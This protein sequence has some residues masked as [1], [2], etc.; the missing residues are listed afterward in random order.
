[1]ALGTPPYS[2]RRTRP[3]R[4]RSALRRWVT[5][6][7]GRRLLAAWVGAHRAGSLQI[8]PISPLSHPLRRTSPTMQPRNLAA[9]AGRWSATHRKT[10]IIGWLAFVVLA[11]LDRRQ[12]RPEDA[13]DARRWATATPSAPS[14]SST[15]RTSPQTVGERVLVQGKGSVKA[16]GPEVTAAVKDV[17]APPLPDQGR[18]RHPEPARRQAPR[19]HRLQGRPLGRRQLLDARRVRDRRGRSTRSRSSPAR[20]WPPSPPSRRRI[21]SCASTSTAPPPQQRALG[22]QDRADEAKQMKFS[23]VGTLLILLLAF[24]A[25]VAAGVPLLLG[26][27]ALVA[28][29]GLLGPVSQLVPAA[30]GGGA[31]RDARRPGRRRRLRDVLHAPDDGGA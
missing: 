26:V 10:A 30:C 1:M 18:H 25:A 22:P 20:R 16:D 29:T 17:V 24:G 28:T 9:R 5:S 14:R 7:H 12:G 6:T 23:L 2:P 19:R 8:P 31:G 4:V 13:Q 27:S 11:T 3:A 21:P 15:R